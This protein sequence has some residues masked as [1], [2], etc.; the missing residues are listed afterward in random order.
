METITCK[1]STILGSKRM[2]QRKLSIRAGLSTKT[3]NFLYNDRWEKVG[4]KTMGRICE[5]LD[6]TP[7]E[8]FEYALVGEGEKDSPWPG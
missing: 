6:I 2:S 4:R 5:A 1:L 7:G 8:L 3:V